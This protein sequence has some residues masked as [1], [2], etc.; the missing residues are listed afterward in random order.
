VRYEKKVLHELRNLALARIHYHQW[1]EFLD[2]NGRGHAE[3]EAY[4]EFPER[5]LLFEMKLSGG[6]MARLQMEG[7]YK[8][9][10]EHIYGKPVVCLLIT[11][12]VR[13]DTPGPFFNSPE[14]FVASGLSFGTW[15]LMLQA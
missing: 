2:A 15:Q 14:A 11:K 5:L 7:L 6:P 9:L 4:I 12:L 8:P 1:I 3:P 13:G 10:L